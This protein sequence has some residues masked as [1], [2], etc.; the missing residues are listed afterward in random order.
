MPEFRHG[1]RSSY[2]KPRKLKT[3]VENGNFSQTF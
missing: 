1:H 2:Q 3:M